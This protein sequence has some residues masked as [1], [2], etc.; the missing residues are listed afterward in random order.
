[1][2]RYYGVYA[3]RVRKDYAKSSSVDLACNDDLDD[4][5]IGEKKMIGQ[6][7]K[8]DS[9]GNGNCRKFDGVISSKFERS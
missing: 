4:L 7:H 1:M 2:V 5:S 6:V 3:N 9:E 8:R